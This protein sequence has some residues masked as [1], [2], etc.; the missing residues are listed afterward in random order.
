MGLSETGLTRMRDNLARLVEAGDVPG[1]VAL[2]RSG[3]RTHALAL[4]ATQ[5]GGSVPMRRDTIF[6]IA[7]LTKGI[8]SA[9]ALILVE[10]CRL[11]LDDP[12]GD[13]LPELAAPRVLRSLDAAPDDT[14]PADGPVTVRHLL[15]ATLGTGAIMAPPG[16]YPI[17]QAIDEQSVG[18]GPDG[19]EITADEWIKRLGALPLL[20]QPGTRWL[21]HT[22]Y[23]VLGVLV[24]RASGQP[25]PEFLR[26]RL[27][28]P[29]GMHDT[30]Y[31]L[32]AEKVGRMAASYRPSAGGL[33]P[34][35]APREG[36]WDRAPAFHSGG[37]GPGLVS[38]V[39]DYLA[40]LG[41]LADRG[42]GILSRPSVELMTSDQLLP[43][44]KEGTEI[45]LGRGGWGF[46]F[47]VESVHDRLDSYPGRF[48]WT[49]GLGVS[50]AADRGND[51][52]G[53]VFTQV[54]MD[55]PLPPRAFLDFWTSAYAALES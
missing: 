28:E 13:L 50:A 33:E 20:H 52:V 10:E 25:L 37:G 48:G 2:V 53:M 55:S 36:H 41:M 18:V 16:T 27:F 42:R 34:R 31:H 40:F 8:T 15:T 12:V 17:Q 23:D 35:D 11:R 38:T 22:S 54:A 14:V 21:Y 5:V 39:D 44:Q 45:F 6:R 7:S 49:G 30:G 26:E 1:L 4:G 29:L 19:P 3:G 51:L 43:A 46:G 9:A 32:P 24:A 47:H